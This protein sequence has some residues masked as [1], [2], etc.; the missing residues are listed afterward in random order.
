MSYLKWLKIIDF[1]YI[2]VKLCL[3][4][5]NLRVKVTLA[6]ISFGTPRVSLRPFASFFLSEMNSETNNTSFEITDEKLLESG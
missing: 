6:Q 3:T 4:N 5:D 2:E 1:S